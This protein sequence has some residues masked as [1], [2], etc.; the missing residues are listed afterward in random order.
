[1]CAPDVTQLLQRVSDG[2]RNAEAELVPVLYTELHRLARA[3]LRNERP[4]HTLQATALVNEVYLK[5]VRQS[6]VDWKSRAHFFRVAA[7]N[8]RCILVDYARHRNA[9]KRRGALVS[10]DEALVVSDE[11]CGMIEELEWALKRLAA[12][13]ERQARVVEMRFFAGLT[14]EEIAAVLD[15]DVRTVKRDWEKARAFLY[16]ELSNDEDSGETTTQQ[17]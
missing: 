3:Y 8:M 17:A 6:K 1:M 12:L 13:R 2:D 9:E 4:D 15:L 14:F 5:L 11:Q 7:N 10:L 16:G